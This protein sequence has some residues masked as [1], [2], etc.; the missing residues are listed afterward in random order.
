[1]DIPRLRRNL[2]KHGYIAIL[3]HTDDVNEMRPDLTSLQCMQVL[4]LC[5]SN[6]DA[7]IGLNWEVIA[8][9]ANDLFPEP[10]FEPPETP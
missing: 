10:Q 8:S 9:V 6:H 1:M 5:K 7:C 3:W 4:E 2:A